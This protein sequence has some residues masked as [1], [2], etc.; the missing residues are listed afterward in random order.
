M[1]DI[2]EQ[3]PQ[4][5]EQL[6]NG[7]F[8]FPGDT[9]DESSSTV[10][11][12]TSAEETSSQTSDETGETPEEDVSQESTETESGD[13]GES[14]D[15]EDKKENKVLPAKRDYSKFTPEETEILKTLPNR[16][17]AKASEMLLNI[18]AKEA[19]IKNTQQ[20]QLPK[21]WFEHEN[22]FVLSP[23]FAQAQQTIG[24]ADARIS[25][26]KQQLINIESG[27]NWF[28]FG[29]NKPQEPS[30]QMKLEI[31]EALQD[32]QRVKYESYNKAQQ[33]QTTFKQ[34]YQGAV[35]SMQEAVKKNVESLQENI[36]PKQGQSEA[37]VKML[38]VEFQ[39]HPLASIVG[40]L[41]AV[42]QNQAAALMSA[43]KSK[44]AI[45]VSKLDAKK[46]GKPIGQQSKN[47]DSSKQIINF[48]ELKEEFEQ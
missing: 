43:A 15:I 7:T 8:E 41:Y 40:T 20:G 6:P 36:R 1:H 10:Q 31:Q 48:D 19:E 27:E 39:N 22:A 35:S 2:I 42:A 14:G 25:H 28:N 5:V 38:P 30:V 26:W 17:F 4:P 32:A 11:D 24:E 45:T 9:D 37:A 47:G 33:L 46:V 12:E 23:E 18:K 29:D 13:S 34:R 16:A 21:N 3:T 44:E